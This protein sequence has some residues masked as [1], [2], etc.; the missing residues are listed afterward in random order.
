VE[1]ITPALR[2][3]YSFCSAGAD[4]EEPRL[5]R[6]RGERILVAEAAAREEE[7]ERAQRFA[8]LREDPNAPRVET[9]TP[10][11]TAQ[12]V[13]ETAAA[14]RA[15]CANYY[16]ELVKLMEARVVAVLRRGAPRPAETYACCAVAA[17]TGS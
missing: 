11:L 2:A 16:E 7:K 14:Y 15:I 17:V 13:A 9:G 8:K 1:E 5:L 3:L 4:G 12:Q 6:L 10:R